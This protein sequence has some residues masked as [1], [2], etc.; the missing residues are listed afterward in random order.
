[1]NSLRN[2]GHECVLFYIL[3]LTFCVFGIVILLFEC[4]I[5]YD[6]RNKYL[7]GWSMI[8]FESLL[9]EAYVAQTYKSENETMIY[10]E[11]RWRCK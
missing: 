10:I 3:L 5:I 8:N 11:W 7:V 1:M 9:K 2:S 4:H 6:D